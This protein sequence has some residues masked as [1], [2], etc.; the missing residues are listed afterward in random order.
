MKHV[1]INCALVTFFTI[2]W[3]AHTLAKFEARC[4]INAF[5]STQVIENEERFLMER[6]SQLTPSGVGNSSLEKCGLSF[7][8]SPSIT[9]L[10]TSAQA[11]VSVVN[12]L[13][14]NGDTYIFESSGTSSAASYIDSIHEK[15][16]WADA[17][18]RARSEIEI[19]SDTPFNYR[20]SMSS[21]G[22]GSALQR[23]F[24]GV[25]FHY[26]DGRISKSVGDARGLNVY[27]EEGYITVLPGAKRR[28]V[29]VGQSDTRGMVSTE[30]GEVLSSPLVGTEPGTIWSYRLELSPASPVPEPASQWMILSGLLGLGI[31]SRRSAIRS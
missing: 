26:N 27:E 20:L 17:M 13:T 30:L 10:N 29:F 25:S 3:S 6:D 7:S 28:V 15:S 19:Y 2:F 22:T 4:S 8:Y 16:P 1:Q 18:S 14:I 23:G 21:Y 5:A 9:I 12:N 11:T 24:D 31:W